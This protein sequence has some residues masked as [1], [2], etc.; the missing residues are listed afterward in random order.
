M[1]SNTQGLLQW[2]VAAHRALVRVLARVMIRASKADV[3][4]LPP[5]QCDVV[6]LDFDA[7]HADSYNQLVAMLRV[8]LLTAD[9]L[10]DNHQEALTFQGNG[11]RMRQFFEN[12]MYECCGGRAC[13][14]NTHLQLHSQS[15][16]VTGNMDVCCTGGDVVEV[17]Q[18]LSEWHGVPIPDA[19]RDL[20]VD[21]AALRTAGHLPP[22][23][24][25]LDEHHVLHPVQQALVH[26]GQ[27]DCCL[28]RGGGAW[29]RVVVV[30]PCLHLLCVEHAQACGS[31]GDAM[32]VR[33]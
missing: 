19:L 13:M 2:D 9:W 32:C 28:R 10:D 14:M 15:C 26:G 17:V 12:L 20:V 23:L 16:N 5:L 25:L 22:D 18:M 21:D 31:P 8:N 30:A 4:E 33:G 3:H 29:E 11:K 6:K 27:C 24:P 7:R 1:L